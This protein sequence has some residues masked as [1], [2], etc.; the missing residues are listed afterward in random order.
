MIVR[1]ILTL[2]VS[3][4]LQYFFFTVE[5][6]KNI[7]PMVIS[8]GGDVPQMLSHCTAFNDRYYVFLVLNAKK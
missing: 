4:L 1:Y 8:N 3:K 7:I 5:K 2:N 6:L